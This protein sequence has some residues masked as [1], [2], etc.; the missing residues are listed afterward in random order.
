MRIYLIASV[1]LAIGSD[2]ARLLPCDECNDDGNQLYSICIARGII[3]KRTRL[4]LFQGMHRKS[5]AW[6]STTLS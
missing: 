3:V 6:T 4:S 5:I 2:L 1:F